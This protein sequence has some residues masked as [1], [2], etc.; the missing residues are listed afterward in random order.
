MVTWG[1]GT[2]LYMIL[3]VSNN[4]HA[5]PILDDS[6]TDE[7]EMIGA[8]ET[9]GIVTEIPKEHPVTSVSISDIAINV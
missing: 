3:V 1:F 2:C 9:E 7:D 8:V 5:V 4:T 6:D